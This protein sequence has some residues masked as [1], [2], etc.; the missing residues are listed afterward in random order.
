ML[1]TV[2][3]KT[4]TKTYDNR[5][6]AGN[7]CRF[8]SVPLVS[9]TGKRSS[10][11]PIFSA[12]QREEHKGAKMCEDLSQLGIDVQELEFKS[13][14]CCKKCA[15][16]IFSSYKFLSDLKRNLYEERVS[17]VK[18]LASGSPS[19]S[20][21]D[22]KPR[23][24]RESEVGSTGRARGKLPLG[25]ATS[26]EPLKDT[27]E[28][29]MRSFMDFPINEPRTVTKVIVGHP[30]SNKVRDFDCQDIQATIVR[31]AT[32]KNFKS[33]LFTLLNNE[34]TKAIATEVFSTKISSESQKFAKM[35]NSLN[36]C[37]ALLLFLLNSRHIRK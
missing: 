26:Q 33:I 4:P 17:S 2:P 22:P 3:G 18:R 32:E 35:R 30:G 28:E 8:C 29:V 16:Q 27:V 37:D 9:E 34:E 12:T 13:K 21:E 25:P 24:W 31:R 5:S 10:S 36:T 20:V 15:R 11:V 23:G 6:T 14:R 1:N 19:D 7:T